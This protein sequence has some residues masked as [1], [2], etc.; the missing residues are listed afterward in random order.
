MF[1]LSRLS[2]RS[3]NKD[4]LSTK[5]TIATGAEN[6]TRRKSLTNYIRQTLQVATVLDPSS[7]S[8]FNK[9]KSPLPPPPRPRPPL[10]PSQ[11]VE[12]ITTKMM[13]V[14]LTIVDKMRK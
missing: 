4:E 3:K 1:S 14:T 5:T 6:K 10:D 11:Q 12:R 8:S 2:S 9:I 13:I 7:S